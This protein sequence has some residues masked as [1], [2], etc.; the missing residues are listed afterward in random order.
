MNGVCFESKR[1]VSIHDQMVLGFGFKYSEALI[2]IS[3]NNSMS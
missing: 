3:R 1:Q 2:G